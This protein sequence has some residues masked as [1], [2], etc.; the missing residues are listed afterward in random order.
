MNQQ[1]MAWS[2]SRVK[3]FKSCPKK[4]YHM[5]IVPKGHLDK[6]LFKQ[7]KAGARGEDLHKVMEHRILNKIA[8]PSN[9]EY[10]EPLAKVI[11]AAPGTALCEAQW[12]LDTTFKPCGTKDWDRVYVRAVPDLLKVK[13]Y[14]AVILDYK[15]GKP[16][17]DEYQLK[18]NAG[19]GFIQ[20]PDVTKITTS[21][22]YFK[23]GEL[24]KP[25]TYL[26]ENLTEIWRDLLVEP[27]KIE[28]SRATNY[29]PP[30]PGRHCSWCD[31]NAARKC[32]FA[33]EPYREFK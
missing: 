14:A 6:V 23:I 10:L 19:V 9:F 31:V 4:L 25:V 8:L 26:R 30:K 1:P 27:N 11:D 2:A 29:W 20:L 5:S 15:T 33:S 7:G 24:S 28:E 17:F 16:E 13:D 18:L 3:T 22:I 32:E 21:Y 12:A